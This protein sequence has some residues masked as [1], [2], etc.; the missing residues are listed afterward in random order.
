MTLIAVISKP[1]V[2]PRTVGLQECKGFR[3]EF[4]G[5]GIRG[6]IEATQ[7]RI[8]V[9]AGRVQR[10]RADRI[11]EAAAE[12]AI[13]QC[14]GDMLKGMREQTQKRSNREKT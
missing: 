3:I 12:E 9:Q 5:N 1:V 14:M 4:G 8:D 7:E 10:L 11:R 6:A 2:D 13:L